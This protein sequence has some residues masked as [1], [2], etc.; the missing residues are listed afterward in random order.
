MNIKA[1]Q[2]ALNKELEDFEKVLNSALPRYTELIHQKQLTPEE[3]EE[4]GDLEYF[5]IE[6]NGKLAQIKKQLEHDLFGLSLDL[7][8]KLKKQAINGNVAASRKL[9]TMRKAFDKSLKGDSLITW[10]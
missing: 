8:Y 6:I 3:L 2:L 1:Y 5:L 7:Y 4:L 10:N 9:L